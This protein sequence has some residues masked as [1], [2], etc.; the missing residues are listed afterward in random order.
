MSFLFLK[1]QR[2]IKWKLV[3]YYDKSGWAHLTIMVNIDIDVVWFDPLRQYWHYI[4]ADIDIITSYDKEENRRISMF[5]GPS[6]S[7][8]NWTAATYQSNDK[9][10]TW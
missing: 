1:L 4:W 2:K 6:R 5:T 3:W 9:I 8:Q 10:I 7:K